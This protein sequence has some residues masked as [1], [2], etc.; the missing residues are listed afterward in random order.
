MKWLKEIAVQ[1]R[2]RKR[3]L[4]LGTKKIYIPEE[5]K[6]IG[7]LA[8][9]SE[10]Y[11]ISKEY[12]RNKWGYK[13]RITGLFYNEKAP[14][15]VEAFSHKH[16]NFLG[17]ASDYFNEF[18]TEKMDFILVPSLQLNPYL[19]YLLLINRSGFNIGF[20]SEENKPF[21]DL[22]LKIEENDLENNIENLINYLNKIKE[23]C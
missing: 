22:M 8:N 20:Y 12:L 2:L 13:I 7:I 18:C 14:E 17:Q 23:A 5:F 11:K 15:S 16:F 4:Y 3:L 10:E 1:R 21:L 9:S 19:R 6:H